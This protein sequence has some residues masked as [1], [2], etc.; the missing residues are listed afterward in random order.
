[1]EMNLEEYKLEIHKHVNRLLKEKRLEIKPK[2]NKSTGEIKFK[3]QFI[4]PE[5]YLELDDDLQSNIMIN[6]QK[7]ILIQI[8]N[9]NEEDL[10]NP[11]GT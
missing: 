7:H 6:L 9:I 11:T 10:L 3:I 5:W 8:D 2:R 4:P 1:M